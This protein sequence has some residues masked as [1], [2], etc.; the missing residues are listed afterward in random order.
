MEKV[1]TNKEVAA[2]RY[3]MR[4]SDSRYGFRKVYDAFIAGYDRAIQDIAKE[5]YDGV[6][7]ALDYLDIISGRTTAN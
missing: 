1:K 4:F 5:T 7:L 2:E 3:A 6:Q